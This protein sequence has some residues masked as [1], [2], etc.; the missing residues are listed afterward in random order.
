MR[1]IRWTQRELRVL[2]FGSLWIALADLIACYAVL[3]YFTF[4]G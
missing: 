3:F 4:G 2:L 1:G